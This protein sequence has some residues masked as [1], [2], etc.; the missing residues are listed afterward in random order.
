MYEADYR[1]ARAGGAVGDRGTAAI[2]VPAQNLPRET[3]AAHGIRAGGEGQARRRQMD[4]VG[5]A[6]GVEHVRPLQKSRERLAI[7]AVADEAEAFRRRNHA[8][9]AAHAAAAAAEREVLGR[10]RHCGLW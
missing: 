3:Y 7:R 4:D 2:G 8:R 6:G 9:D 1:E 5:A 10:E